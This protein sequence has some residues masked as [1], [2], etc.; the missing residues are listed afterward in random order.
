MVQMLRG[1]CP[2][3]HLEATLTLDAVGQKVLTC[4]CAP[5]PQIVTRENLDLTFKMATIFLRGRGAPIRFVTD[6]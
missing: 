5:E 4:G 2:D 6:E 1:T 3:C